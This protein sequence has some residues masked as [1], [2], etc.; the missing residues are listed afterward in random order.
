MEEVPP[1]QVVLQP[2][3]PQQALRDSIDT[4]LSDT[5]ECLSSYLK[6]GDGCEDV[7]R[8]NH[9]ELKQIHEVETKIP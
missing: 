3:A 8:S 2:Q 4:G 7:P 9:S 5:G 6:S 1:G